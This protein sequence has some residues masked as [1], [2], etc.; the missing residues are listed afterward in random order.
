MS[1]QF[2]PHNLWMYI[3]AVDTVT[4]HGSSQINKQSSPVKSR[5]AFGV[6][7]HGKR[8]SGY[9][10]YDR[11]SALHDTVMERGGVVWSG[12]GD[13]GDRRVQKVIKMSVTNLCC[14]RCSGGNSTIFYFAALTFAKIHHVYLLKP[15]YNCCCS[16]F[17]KCVRN[18][19]RLCQTECDVVSF[20]KSQS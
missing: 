7:D 3:Y 11:P 19:K 14:L 5:L 20:D 18:P 1:T 15:M 13:W 17:F 10:G 4:C 8:V 6:V 2:P 9:N 12:G 16:L